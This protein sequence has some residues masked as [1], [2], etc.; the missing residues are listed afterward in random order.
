MVHTYVYVC[1]CVCRP[2][3]Q[4]VFM[5]NSSGTYIC[6]LLPFLLVDSDYCKSTLSQ[7]NTCCCIFL[8]DLFLFIASSST[9]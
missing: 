1:L 9:C 5:V 7:S 2:V 4:M 6:Y 8:L 3:S